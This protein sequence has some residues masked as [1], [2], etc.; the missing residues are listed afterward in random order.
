MTYKELLELPD[1]LD[2]RDR[3]L[4]R[5]S[6]RCVRCS[7][8]VCLQVHHLYYVRG[9]KPWDYPPAAVV[10]LCE[11]CHSKTHGKKINRAVIQTE[12]F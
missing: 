6:F 1:W 3:I 2:Y 11:A 12:I 8:A 4:L 9:R 5:D 7:S 10:T